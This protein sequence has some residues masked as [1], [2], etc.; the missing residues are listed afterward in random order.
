MAQ[1]S[2][3]KIRY[4]VQTV[5]STATKGIFDLVLCLA[6]VLRLHAMEGAW[7]N[8]V[9]VITIDDEEAEEGE[10]D[11]SYFGAVGMHVEEEEKKE[12]EEIFSQQEGVVC[13]DDDDEVMTIA[14]SRRQ[15]QQQQ[16]DNDGGH[17][18]QRGQDG[19]EMEIFSQENDEGF[20]V[21]EIRQGH[22]QQQQQQQK[23]QKR[24][25]RPPAAETIDLTTTPTHSQHSSSS[26]MGAALRMAPVLDFQDEHE[27]LM[28]GAERGVYPFEAVAELL[29][30]HPE[31]W[32]CRYDAH[33]HSQRILSLRH[34]NE[35]VAGCDVGERPVV[36][37][38][39]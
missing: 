14:D 8:E 5:V 1:V 27:E 37:A 15:Q 23:Q 28:E 33:N 24:L 31:H 6:L 38:K 25:P 11:G 16:Q 19:E 7:S 12:E 20:T 3:T 26:P 9:E 35:E 13:S 36:C 32:W 4:S 34:A 30:R 18:M 2:Y 29:L 10:S 39:V 21:A 22:H 17:V